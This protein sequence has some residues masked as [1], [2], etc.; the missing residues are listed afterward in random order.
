M[1][2]DP[3]FR[4]LLARLA[5]VAKSG[6]V[7]AVGFGDTSVGVT[8]LDRLGIAHTSNH[9]ARIAGVV[10][11]ARRGQGRVSSNRVNLFAK[12][13]DWE[14]SACKS[15]REI[16]ERFGYDDGADRKLFCTV[17]AK[18]PNSLGLMFRVSSDQKRLEEVHCMSDSEEPVASWRIESLEARLEESH[19]ESLWVVANSQL[20]GKVEYFQYRYANFTG[21]PKLKLLSRLIAEGTVTMDH[22][23]QA[24]GGRVVEKGPLFKI[25]PENFSALFSAPVQIDL[26]SL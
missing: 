2:N 18:R 16:L 6:P 14:I 21:P 23:I 15:S 7:R 20:R 19:P 9:K 4:E 17:N 13:P 1:R 22:L 12:V 8:L 24:S 5:V 10:I 26:L 11:A 3:E 25:R